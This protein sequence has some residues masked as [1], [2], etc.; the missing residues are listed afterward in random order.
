M[1]LSPLLLVLIQE[2]HEERKIWGKVTLES[3]YLLQTVCARA[4]L[5]IDGGGELEQGSDFGARSIILF[6]RARLDLQDY[7]PLLEVFAFVC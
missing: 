7:C 2:G 4:L 6:P 1:S 3:K 5:K